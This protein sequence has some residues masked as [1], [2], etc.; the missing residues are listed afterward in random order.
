MFDRTFIVTNVSRVLLRGWH[1]NGMWT[2]V[3]P[4]VI[5]LCWAWPFV[6][7][8]ASL[9]RLDCMRAIKAKS[10]MNSRLLT[11]GWQYRA[12]LRQVISTGDFSEDNLRALARSRSF[13]LFSAIASGASQE[14]VA[15]IRRSFLDINTRDP[16]GLTALHYAVLLLD[17]P[18]VEALINVGADVNMDTRIEASSGMPNSSESGLVPLHLVARPYD[19]REV[20]KKK[21]RIAI[22]DLLL[23]AGANLEVLDI[24]GNSP[25]QYAV[26]SKHVALA[27]LFVENSPNMVGHA[28]FRNVYPLHR[29]AAIRNAVSSM[30]M[31][32]LLLQ[33]GAD[34][35]V[36]IWY[37]GWSPRMLA[38]YFRHNR[39]EEI[40]RNHVPPAQI[41]LL[42]RLQVRLSTRPPQID[43]FAHFDISTRWIRWV[44]EQ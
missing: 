40:L 34:P 7:V 38:R 25:L 18:V 19:L 14:A 30:A 3:V 44:G 27:R 16:M 42:N 33:H 36:Y 22:A 23:R 24:Y 41:G 37:S 20:H 31:V 32:R 10:Q 43:S 12:K 9:Q 17:V 13:A 26:Q 39:I 5:G 6:C 28:N 1:T 29:A 4:L 35:N 11:Q 15:L 21:K 2:Q 8:E